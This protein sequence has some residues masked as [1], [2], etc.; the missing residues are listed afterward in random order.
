MA[1]RFTSWEDWA[2]ENGIDPSGP[3]PKRGEGE[4]QARHDWFRIKNDWLEYLVRQG[5]TPGEAGIEDVKEK[6]KSI[7]AGWTQN[8]NELLQSSKLARQFASDPSFKQWVNLYQNPYV[9]FMNWQEMRIGTSSKPTGGHVDLMPNG[10]YYTGGPKGDWYD[11]FGR[12]QTNPGSFTYG[13]IRFDGKTFT[14]SSGNPI[15]KPLEALRDAGYTFQAGPG[16]GTGEGGGQSSFGLTAPYGPPSAPPSSTPVDPNTGRAMASWKGPPPGENRQPPKQ[17]GDPLPNNPNKDIPGGPPPGTNVPP[18]TPAPGSP[19]PAGVPQEVWDA[20]IRGINASALQQSLDTQVEK[21]GLARSLRGEY[22]ANPLLQ[23]LQD[24]YGDILGVKFVPGMSP[25]SG[26]SVQ[27]Q[28]GRVIHAP[29]Q[30]YD[31]SKEAFWGMP[32][33]DNVGAP[34]GSIGGVQLPPLGSW[35]KT[36]DPRAPGRSFGL[37]A[38]Y[39]Q[40]VGQ[41]VNSQVRMLKEVLQPGGERNR[42]ISG[43]VQ[44]GASNMAQGRLGMVNTAL[45]GLGNVI[46][47]RLGFPMPAYS[48]QSTL[49]PLSGLTGNMFGSQMEYNL[50]LKDIEQRN[51]ASGL[52]FWGDLFKSLGGLLGQAKPPWWS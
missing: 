16:Q 31:P 8:W 9:A 12:L 52:G 28:D 43:A 22:L 49:G 34:G 15:A 40:G 24:F 14:D 44:Q 32:G 35:V 3:P 39:A 27:L 38:P 33:Y 29:G 46:N 36:N 6:G 13:G 5:V 47:T 18:G 1:N 42:A 23:Y 7:F 2:K 25:G 45:G 11:K 30:P 41:D 21:F 26:G 10:L 19:A 17:P 4:N 51:R 50:G 37:L 20:M 48:G